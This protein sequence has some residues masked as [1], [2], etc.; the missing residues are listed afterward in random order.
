MTFVLA[1]RYIE[2]LCQALGVE[3]NTVQRIIID[4]VVGDVPIMYVQSIVDDRILRLT[5]PEAREAK[6]E[7]E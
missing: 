6:I 3:Y 7:V 1:N 2:E 5:P 4:A